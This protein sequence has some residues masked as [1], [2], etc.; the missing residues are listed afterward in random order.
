MSRPGQALSE[1]AVLIALVVGVMVA[2]Q[3]YLKRS[4]QAS[5]KGTADLMGSQAQGIRSESGDRRTAGAGMTWARD[6]MSIT[7]SDLR[8]GVTQ[9]VGGKR[10][11]TVNDLS[12]NDGA[13]AVQNANGEIVQDVSGYTQTIS[14]VHPT[15]PRN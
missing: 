10:V 13:L 7:A 2:V 11:R 4:I 6:S 9:A 3:P 8:S 15:E 1:L 14:R 12:V 5:I